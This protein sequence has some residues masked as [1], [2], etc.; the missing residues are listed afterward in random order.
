VT[1]DSNGFDI[2]VV[3]VDDAAV[4]SISGDLDIATAPRLRKELIELSNRGIRAVLVD[5][6]Q[7][8]FIDSTG[9][10][11]LVSALR[12]FREHGGDLALQSPKP[13]AAKIFEMTGLANVFAIS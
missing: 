1:P 5:L 4:V 9:L 12:R 11:V 2:E 7:L 3:E 8:E 10:G 6:A 13:A